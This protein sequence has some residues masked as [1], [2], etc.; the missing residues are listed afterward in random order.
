MVDNRNFD[1]HQKSKYKKFVAT[2]ADGTVYQAD[3]EKDLKKRIS[4]H[5]KQVNPEKT[6]VAIKPLFDPNTGER[7]N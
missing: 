1:K 7:I 5:S 3:S 6:S 4:G 2:M